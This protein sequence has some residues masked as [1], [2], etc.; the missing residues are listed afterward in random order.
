MTP[1]INED[2]RMSNWKFPVFTRPR[3][4]AAHVKVP[5]LLHYGLVSFIVQLDAVGLTTVEGIPGVDG[6]TASFSSSPMKVL[7]TM[8][9]CFS[10]L[11]LH[12]HISI[13]CNNIWVEN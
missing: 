4:E 3:V 9:V 12:S 11:K 5:H 8:L 2:F 13:N 1:V 7:S 6:E 10:K